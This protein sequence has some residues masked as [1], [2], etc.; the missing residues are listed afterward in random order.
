ML[1]KVEIKVLQVLWQHFLSVSRSKLTVVL[2]HR[3][4]IPCTLQDCGT[5][6]CRLGNEQNGEIS[7]TA[8]EYNL[9]QYSVLLSLDPRFGE[10][11]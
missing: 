2:N 3:L 1:T 11:K 4:R 7:A 6:L 8:A 9:T 5:L 10:N